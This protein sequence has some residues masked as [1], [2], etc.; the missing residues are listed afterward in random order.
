MYVNDLGIGRVQAEG[1]ENNTTKT[2]STAAAAGKNKGSYAAAMKN[3]V[4]NQKSVAT[5]TFTTAGDIIIK[6]AFEKMKT[7]PEWEESVMNKVKEYYAGDYNYTADYAQTSYLNLSG[8]GL[9]GYPY[10]G[11]GTLAS[12][13]Y[14][15][16]MNNTL[17]NSLLGSWLL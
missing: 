13:A 4:D 1:Y 6:E 7:D 14:R 15:N 17:N 12:A 11:L 2:A 16:T 5:P 8:M 3:A 10:L 9:T